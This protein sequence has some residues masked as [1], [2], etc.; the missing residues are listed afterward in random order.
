M[1]QGKMPKHFIS[2]CVR[3]VCALVWACVCIWG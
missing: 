1:K 3:V 2:L